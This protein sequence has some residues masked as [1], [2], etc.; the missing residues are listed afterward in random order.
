RF[1]G[2]GIHGALFSEKVSSLKKD[3]P[4]IIEVIVDGQDIEETEI[5]AF[6]DSLKDIANGLLP[7][8]GMTTKG[9][10]MFTGNVYKNGTELFNYKSQNSSSMKPIIYKEL[11]EIPLLKFQGYVWKS[12][13]EEPE[14][15]HNEPYD[16]SNDSETN[17]IVE[18]LL[19]NEEKDISIHI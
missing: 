11:S 2:G 18:A 8:G 5:Q 3:S 13:Q 16:Y 6:E 4:L 1:T 12:D 10:G 19:Y 14:V 17:F 7:L 15:L 9:H